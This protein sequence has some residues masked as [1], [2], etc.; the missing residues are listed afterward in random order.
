MTVTELDAGQLTIESK[1]ERFHHLQGR[2]VP[3]NVYADVGLF[4]ER[5][6]R[7]SLTDSLARTWRL[8]L[9]AFHQ[10]TG[11]PLGVA[12]EWETRS[13]GLWGRWKIGTSAVAQE[14]ASW[15]REG[16]LALS[17]GFQAIRSEWEFTEQF[18]PLRGP[19]FMDRVTRLESRLLEVSLTPTPAFVDAIVDQVEATS[20]DGSDRSLIAQYRH[21]LTRHQRPSHH[22]SRRTTPLR[23]SPLEPVPPAAEPLAAASGLSQRLDDVETHVDQLDT[24]VTTLEGLGGNV[25]PPL[26]PDAAG[27]EPAPLGPALTP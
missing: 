4:L 3:Y 26:T 6:H 18:D 12:E 20:L 13:D 16:G 15:A 27:G 17:I 10:N 19:D 9:L 1:G 11:M 23:Q 25:L 14:A 8:P 7:D 2:A 21:W 5:H 22:M 24:R